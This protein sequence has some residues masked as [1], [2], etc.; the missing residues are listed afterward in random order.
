MTPRF[1]PDGSTL[2][3]YAAGALPQAIA[4]LVAAHAEFCPACRAELGVVRALAGATLAC[5]PVEPVADDAFERLS[6]RLG[7]EISP[8]APLPEPPDAADLPAALARLVG[9]GTGAVAWREVLPG[10]EHCRFVFP[11][12]RGESALRLIRARPGREIPDHTHAG[13]ETTLVLAGALGDGDRVYRTGEF[14]DLDDTT[15]HNPKVH[16][17]ETCLCAIAEEGPPKF[18]SPQ[19]AAYLRQAGI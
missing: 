6:V 9:G 10:I 7:A 12:A 16:G 2:V 15:T 4:I 17:P 18:A 8:C 13:Q 3:S 14:C 1:H 11:S 5:A 19:V